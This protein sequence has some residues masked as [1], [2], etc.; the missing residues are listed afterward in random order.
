MVFQDNDLG[1]TVSA[2][3]VDNMPNFEKVIPS[4]KQDNNYCLNADLL[5]MV[6]LTTNQGT[7]NNKVNLSH[8]GELKASVLTIDNDDTWFAVVMPLKNM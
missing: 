4:G 2:K 8:N 6:A 3:K 1:I 7:K 5:R